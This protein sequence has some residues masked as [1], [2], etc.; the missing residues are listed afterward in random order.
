MKKQSGV[1]AVQ[2]GGVIVREPLT[3]VLLLD[4]AAEVLRVLH[5]AGQA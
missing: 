5:E 1:L 4:D 3:H 2:C